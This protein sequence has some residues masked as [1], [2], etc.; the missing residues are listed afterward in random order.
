[1]YGYSVL[2]REASD[3][4][5]FALV[6][7]SF[8]QPYRSLYFPL[9]KVLA[10][11]SLESIR[12]QRAETELRAKQSTCH[13]AVPVVESAPRNGALQNRNEGKEYLRSSAGSRYRC[14]SKEL[15]SLNR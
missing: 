4:N 2:Q 6:D 7:T 10:E 14:E 3:C 8:D 5:T 13:A 15:T 1:M 11:Q 9:H 12:G